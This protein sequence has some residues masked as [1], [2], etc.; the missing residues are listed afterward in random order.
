MGHTGGVPGRAL[1][2]PQMTQVAVPNRKHLAPHSEV[3]AG[4]RG[5]RKI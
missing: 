5:V 2:A 3:R 1:A 4:V